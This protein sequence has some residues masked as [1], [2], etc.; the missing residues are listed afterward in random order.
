M[1]FLQREDTIAVM[2]AHPAPN[3]N[4]NA[5]LVRANFRFE[6]LAA[7]ALIDAPGGMP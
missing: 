5:F 4:C 7:V 2:S 6:D 1:A 3:N